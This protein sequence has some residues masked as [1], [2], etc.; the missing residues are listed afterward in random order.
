[1]QPKLI[2]FIIIVPL[3]LLTSCLVFA[4]PPATYDLRDVGGVNYVT[5]VKSQIDGTCWTHGSM[6]AI[7]GNL[8]MTGNWEAAGESGEPNLA[9]YHLDWWNGFNQYNNDDTDPP[10]GGGL[11]VHMGGDYR[12]TTAYL[13]RGEGAVRDIDGQSHTPAPPRT[14][15]SWHYYYPR[16]VEWYVA[17]A[18]LGNIN[19]IK[20]KIMSEGVL[21]VCMCYSSSFMSG[22]IHYQPPTDTTSPNHSVAVVGWDDNKVTQAPLSGA[23][24]CKNSWGSSWGENGYFWISYYDK[25]CCQHPEMGAVSFQNVE[26]MPYD[27]I[28]YHDYHGW[29][30]TVTDVTEAF[31]AFTTIDNHILEGVSFFTAADSVAY[32]VKI[33]DRFES[34]ELLDEL[35][36]T[37]GMLEFAGFH[38]IDLETSLTISAGDDFYVYVELSEGGQPYDRTSDVPVLLGARYRVTVESA[39]NPGESY[40]RNG[41]IWYDLYEDNNTAN[42]CIKALCTEV[43]PPLNINFPNGLPDIIAPGEETAFNVEIIDGLE[44]YMPGSGTLHYRYDGGTYLT[45]ALTSLGGDLYEA[46]L[47]SATCE[48]TPEFYISA[49]GDGKTVVLNPPTAPSTVYSCIVGTV[50]TLMSEDFESP[51]GWTT[52]YQSATNGFW[53]CGIPVDDAGWDYDPATDGDGS[54]SCYLTENQLGNTDVD[55]GSVILQSPVFDMSGGG[56]IAYEYYLYLTNSDGAD[57]LLVE[58]SNDGGVSDWTEIVCHDASNGLYWQHYE[59]TE[60][61]LN[62]M[63]ITFTSTMQFRFTANDGDP[64][65]IIEAGIDGLVITK[66]SCDSAWICGDID[67]NGSEPDIVDLIYLVNYM[68]QSGP[69]PPVMEATDVDGSGSGPDIADLIYLVNYMFQE[70]PA[71]NCP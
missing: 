37:S 52:D 64:Q 60:D 18:G 12:V 69:L 39:S 5:S 33:Y 14:D 57:K 11:T 21:A 59:I 68:F 26:P 38:T 25:H 35:T 7:E 36:T 34:D 42:F 30:D 71:P 50:I 47:P 53:Q 9:E 58:L 24:L 27:Y 63:G 10:T 48:S 19:H 67:G 54:G 61:E 16:D 65:S 23:W 15:S 62:T 45:S 3:I 6:A 55:N 20:E 8:L 41:G 22:Y 56:N 13:T 4:D 17:G 44:S 70:G 1:M 40:Y 66:F 2:H 49:E 43:P 32:V 46:I 28:Y 29:R 31:N 51:A